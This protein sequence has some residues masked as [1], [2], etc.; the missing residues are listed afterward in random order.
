M[1]NRRNYRLSCSHGDRKETGVAHSGGARAMR[2]SCDVATTRVRRD[3]V[4]GRRLV[5]VAVWVKVRRCVNIGSTVARGGDV[6][7]T[8]FSRRSSTRSKATL[9]HESAV[10]VVVL[11]QKGTEKKNFNTYIHS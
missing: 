4:Q 8:R 5:V 2:R 10:A 3:D 7:V 9:S 11:L 6:F 1:H